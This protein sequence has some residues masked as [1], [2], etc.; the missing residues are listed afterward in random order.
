MPNKSLP[1]GLVIVGMLAIVPLSSALAEG[2]GVQFFESKIRP[3]LV[4]HCYECHSSKAQK[5]GGSL[6]LESREDILRGGESGAALIPGQPDESLIIQAIRGTDE[7]LA[8]PPKERDPL[9][10]TLVSNFV[11][12][13][14]MGAPDPRSDEGERLDFENERDQGKHWSFQPLSTPTPPVVSDTAWP[15]DPIDLFVLARLEMQNHI[16]VRDAS[17]ETLVRRLYFDLIGLAPSIEEVRSF[18]ASYEIESQRAAAQLVDQLLASPHF[19]ERWGRHWLDVARYGESNGNDGLGRNPTFPHAWRYRDY[20]IKAFNDD[21]PYDRFLKE[22]IAGDLLPA[23]TAEQR[24]RQLVATGFLAIGSKPALAMN[25]N[26]AMDVVDDQID[27]VSTT[28]MALSVSCARCH[29]HKHDPISSRDYYALAGIFNS[30]ETLWGK[31]GNEK[32]T[33]QPT[34]L[35]ELRDSLR[36]PDPKKA[37]APPK[38]AKGYGKSIDALKPNIHARLNSKPENVIVE[39]G[40]KFSDQEYATF[41]D[42]R[43]RIESSIPAENYSVSFWF[44]NDLDNSTRAI[45]AYLF[46]HAADGD[47]DQKG[48]HIGIGGSHDKSRT[49]KLYIWNGTGKDQNIAGSKVIPKGK[50]HHIVLTRAGKKV[51]LYLNGEPKPEIEGELDIPASENRKIFIGARNDR[52]AP[53]QGSLAELVIF[54]RALSSDESQLLHKESGQR[55]GTPQQGFAMGVRD[56]RQIVDCKINIDGSSKKLGPIVPRGFLSACKLKVSPPSIPGN[57]SG[58]TQLADWLTRGDHPQTARV[59]A[60][61][62]WLH[63][64]GQAIVDTPDDFGVYGARPSHPALL[65]H[66]ANRFLAENWS[67][68]KLIRTIVL[69]RSYQLDSACADKELLRDDPDNILIG[70]HS[71]RRLDA[72]SLRDRILQASGNLD[73][74]PA[75]GSVI[76]SLDILINWPPGEAKYLHQPSNHRSVYLCMLRNS[77]PLDLAAFDF[78]DGTKV[79]GKRNV[80]TPPTQAL[81]LLN[82]PL[83]VAQSEALANRLLNEVESSD[84]ARISKAYQRA[85]QRKPSPDEIKRTLVHINELKK[86]LPGDDATAKAWASFCQVLLAS[87][88]FRYID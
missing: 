48:D 23:S 72:E 4:Q 61:R 62:I 18:A 52:F 73:L 6:S 2:E 49:G 64:F 9:P 78:P 47:K 86:V 68:K 80:S 60:N 66:L 17:G 32:L 29:D 8:M 10:E 81:F 5:L 30:T 77:P 19:G 75:E 13:V 11:E 36:A 20:V 54:D 21:V 3:A 22:Q 84:E 14:K 46:S 12:W 27:V 56:K 40:V 83:V 88:E 53:L 45:T 44:R 42:G 74:Q 57:S 15:R 16:P 82:N 87:N 51:R 67:V 37:A 24:N 76:R 39:K 28:V 35:H 34:E 69:T 79:T 71:R 63:L 55:R 43:L 59:M 25:Q 58:R 38:F 1:S 33:A 7:D 65:D 26:F 70:R 85:L 41:K 50:W 31:A